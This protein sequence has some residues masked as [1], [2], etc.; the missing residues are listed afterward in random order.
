MRSPAQKELPVALVAGGASALGSALCETLLLQN[1]KVHCVDNLITGKRENLLE[2]E[3]KP[4]FRFVQA[5]ITTSRSFV[6]KGLSYIFHLAGEAEYLD[7]FDVNLESLVVNAIGTKRLLDLARQTK[8]KFLLVSAVDVYSGFLSSLSL[9]YYFGPNRLA[10]KKFSHH[11][12]KRFAEAL[13]FAYFKRYNVDARIVRLADVYGPKMTLETGTILSE[14]VTAAVKDLPLRITGEGLTVC[15][16][17]YISDVVYGLMKA[18]FNQGTTGKIY[19][20]VSPEE[21]TVVNLIEVIRKLKPEIEVVF[22]KEKEEL[23][24]P[25]RKAELLLSQR[26]LG[27]RPKVSLQKGFQTTLDWFES[28]PN[29]M[30][31]LK[32]R[33]KTREK[34]LKTEKDKLEKEIEDLQSLTEVPKKRSLV[35]TEEVKEE[36]I[37]GEKPKKKSRVKGIEEEALS[38]GSLV[39]VRSSA[40]LLSQKTDAVVITESFLSQLG[41]FISRLRR[42]STSVPKD[43]TGKK[44]AETKKES[45]G[46]WTGGGFIKQQKIKL[47]SLRTRGFSGFTLN[48]PRPHLH[49]P[50]LA[51]PSISLRR[52]VFLV[53]AVILLS[54]LFCPIGSLIFFALSGGQHLK[55]SYQVIMQGDLGVALEHAQLAEARLLKARRSLASLGYLSSMLRKQEEVKSWDLFLSASAQVAGGLEHAFLAWQPL[56]KGVKSILASDGDD[57]GLLI[58]DAKLD[59]DVA[60]DKLDLAEGEFK[61]VDSTKIPFFLKASLEKISL[62]VPRA[63]EKLTK[64]RFALSF[65]PGVTGIEGRRTYLLLLQ[66]NMELRPG[67]GF[68]GSYGLVS[69][70]GGKLT[71]IEIEDVYTADGV[72]KEAILSPPAIREYLG[73]G[74]WYLRDSNFSAHFPTNAAQAEWFLEKSLGVKVDGVI[75][76]DLSTIQYLLSV[77]GPVEII[78]Y[79]ETIDAKNVFER[80]EYHS[81]ADFFPGSTSKRDFLG[82]LARTILDQTLN[83]PEEKWAELAAAIARALEEKHMMIYFHDSRLAKLLA[84]QQW[85]GAVLVQPEISDQELFDYLMIVDANLGA[86]KVN[87]F[88]RRE[89]SHLVVIDKNGGLAERLTIEYD[90]QSPTETWP[91]GVYR[92]F[93]RVYVPAGSVLN[94]VIIGEATDPALVEKGR[95]LGKTVFAMNVEVPIKSKKTVVL[96]YQL[97]NVLK[98]F[99]GVGNYHFLVQKQPGV[100]DD[101]LTVIVNY[102]SFMKIVKSEPTGKGGEQALHYST[103]LEKDREFKIEFI[104]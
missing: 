31:K 8:A 93:L 59:L 85:D 71:K 101:H 12:V 80:A 13:V 52:L 99:E 94:K 61:N 90:N 79:Q 60:G 92:N 5:D 43:E 63:R 33:L 40:Q 11:E 68:I 70:V 65:L 1:L 14:L 62:E 25:A 36:K 83:A 20:L 96:E 73:Q 22:S 103:T 104:K 34:Q 4:N 2:L 54:G 27:W 51:F 16:P 49:V 78:D 17:T 38:E 48:I 67:G 74:N 32:T 18:I 87:Y 37:K 58:G 89:I 84:D 88:L 45:P 23:K 53:S 44:E 66:N 64:L 95:E 47:G 39:E 30:E 82:S 57:L 81:E 69:F 55:S 6:Y 42:P 15:H 7:G 77:M 9:E 41:H 10:E 29:R 24:F 3:T 72:F 76:L 46:L 75:G 56:L 50:T 100:I 97:P 28:V 19:N 102:P 86:N 26:D 91:G 98:F 21:I 35:T